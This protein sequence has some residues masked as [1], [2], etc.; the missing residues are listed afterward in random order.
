M[1]LDKDLEQLEKLGITKENVQ[2]QVNNFEKGF[3]FLDIVKPAVVGD[4]IIRLECSEVDD[5]VDLF[6]SYDGSR[7]KFVPASGAA[8]RMFKHLFEFLEEYP[9]KGDECFND[10][11]FNSVWNFF[12][13]IKKFAFY[14][15]L[16][17]ELG[18]N[19][20][21]IDELLDN[22]DY[23]TILKALLEPFALNYGNLPKGLIRFHTYPEGPRTAFEEHLT[24]G[25]QYARMNT[26]DVSLHLT[27]SPEHRNGFEKLA[28]QVLPSFQESHGV[29]FHIDY[30]E[31]KV[32]T[33]TIAVD[34]FNKP[35]RNYDGSLV[36]RPGGHG[37]LLE[38]LNDINAE[39]IFVKNIDNVVPDHLKP[40]TVLY[41]KALAGLLISYQSLVFDY[42]SQLQENDDISI[43]ILQ[44]ILDFTINE[45]CIIPP[46]NLNQ[47]NHK[48]LQNYLTQKLN[49]PIRVCGM[50]K[51][52]GE[53]GGGPFWAT[54]P[55][56]SIS[57]QVVETSQIDLD[58]LDKRKLVDSATHFNP[59]DLICAV[60]DVDGNKFNLMNFSDPNTGF[61]SIKSKDG[62]QLKAQELPGLWN[63]AMSD[64]ITIFVEVPLITFNPVKSVNDLLRDQHQSR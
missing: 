2:Y 35:F 63:G 13:N 4:G 31:Q 9:T 8:T 47:N 22:K 10:R 7:M 37:A 45:L 64:W 44:E 14:S 15:L 52:E 39:L 26:N 43:D 27:V 21:N 12:E 38:N 11:S 57:L 16:A 53:P 1:L 3:P 20:Y 30:S 19:K 56:G 40:Q 33:N 6:K 17:K 51:N 46:T 49:R 60:N 29:N 34:E 32:S 23:T 28:N 61:I 54:N 5:L 62:K 59:V 48:E 58:N 36:F 42:L 50:V 24:E 41:K 55:D 18:D 25:A